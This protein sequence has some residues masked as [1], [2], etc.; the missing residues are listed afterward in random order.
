MPFAVMQSGSLVACGHLFVGA[1]AETERVDFS[2]TL[3]GASTYLVST[4][5]F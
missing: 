2:S 1:K 4:A 3:I 5:T